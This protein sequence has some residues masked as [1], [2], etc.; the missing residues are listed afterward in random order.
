MGRITEGVAAAIVLQPHLQ[1][2]T[3][4]YSCEQERGGS[5][6]HRSEQ[7]CVSFADRKDAWNGALASCAA[8]GLRMG[9][10]LVG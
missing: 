9:R 1:H 3:Q 10:S 2:E 6:A 8:L 4:L 5:P 7:K